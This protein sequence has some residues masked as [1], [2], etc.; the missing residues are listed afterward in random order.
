MTNEQ[1]V[2]EIRNGYSVTDNMQSLYEKNLPLIRAIVRP[3]AVYE[4][5]E[6]LL[7]EAYF[8]IVQAINHYETA[9]NVKFMTYAKF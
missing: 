2:S 3:Y 7:Q 4:P 1:I 9:E 6:D 5:M 8:G